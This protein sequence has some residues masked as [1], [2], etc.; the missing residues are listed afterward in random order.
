MSFIFI[1]S[2]YTHPDE[3]IRE[4]RYRQVSRYLAYLLSTHRVAF[5]PIS[6]CHNLAKDFVLPTRAV[7]WFYYNFSIMSVASALHVLTLEGWKESIGVQA[8]IG[9]WRAIR[10]G[11]HITYV[12][13]APDKQLTRE[14][15]LCSV[16]VKK[17][18]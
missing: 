18:G 10:P 14:T 5:S 7:D 4:Q 3:N 13:M 2:P 15:T 6:A 12:D 1:S 9:F 8:E 11:E 16:P 17:G